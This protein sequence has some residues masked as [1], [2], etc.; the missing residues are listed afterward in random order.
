M[1]K[2]NEL[3]P[4]DLRDICS[5]DLFDL[6]ST[7]DENQTNNELIY[8]QERGIKALQFVQILISKAII[9]I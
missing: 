8:G 5:P 1:R 9:Y 7:N 4:K 3:T 2:K 6:E